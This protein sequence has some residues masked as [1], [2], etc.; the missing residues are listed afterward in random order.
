MKQYIATFHTHFAAM[1]T[2]RAMQ[3]AGVEADLCPVPQALSADCGTCV[4]YR[5][6]DECRGMLHQD[7]D[8]VVIAG[9]GGE[10]EGVL[11]NDAP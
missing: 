6:Q 4:R 7:F 1:S 3:K 5:A 2:Y 10:Y 9:D 11:T 8:R